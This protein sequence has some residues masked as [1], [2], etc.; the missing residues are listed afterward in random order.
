MGGLAIDTEGRVLRED[1]TPIKGLHAAGEV[2]GG[3]HGRNRLGGN[4]L[5]ECAVFGR[6][7]GALKLAE[8]R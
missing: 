6:I 4:A 2:T 7:V 5:T 1:K 3:V 8:R